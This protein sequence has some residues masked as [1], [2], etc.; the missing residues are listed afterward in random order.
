MATLRGALSVI[1]LVIGYWLLPAN[2]DVAVY[3]APWILKG[4]AI[5]V[6]TRCIL[7]GFALFFYSAY[8]EQDHK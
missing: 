8:K 2:G 4:P 3:A 6:V 5:L 1:L 7:G